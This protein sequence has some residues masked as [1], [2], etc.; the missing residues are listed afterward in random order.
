MSMY[1]ATVPQLTKMLQN[2]KGW[3]GKAEAHAASKKFD[4]AVLL[5]ARL[6]PDMH[7]L[8]RQIQSVAD[9]AKFAA[10]RITGKA[11]PSHPDT[12]TTLP[13][14]QARLDAVIAYLA[15]FVEKDFEG[16]ADRAVVL[17]FMP[18]K[19]LLG[20][21]YLNQ[22]ALPNF[23]FHVVAAYMIL[24]HNGVDVGKLDYIGSLPFR[25]A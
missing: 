17:P 11:P 5:Q 2:L 10:A 18:G 14:L 24:R 6:A 8:V 25:D 22:M 21:E 7:P 19:A 16:S 4:V 9:N 13:E 1:R 20:H 15:T 3:L 12:E 23:Y